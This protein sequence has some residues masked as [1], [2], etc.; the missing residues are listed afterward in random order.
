VNDRNLY[1]KAIDVDKRGRHRSFSSS[2]DAVLLDMIREKNDF[3][4]SL[5][6]K[7]PS[8]F[9]GVPL[10]PGRYEN[11]YIVLY[12]RSAPQLFSMRPRL[13][14]IERTLAS[15]PGAPKKLNIRLEVHSV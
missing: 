6:E 10:R 8:L 11:G 3:F 1:G 4:D 7:W 2:V 9:P 12:V 15:L 14:A 5:A 13:K